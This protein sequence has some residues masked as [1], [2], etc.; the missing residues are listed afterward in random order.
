MY[1]YVYVCMYKFL[2]EAENPLQRK[3]SVLLLFLL[4]NPPLCLLHEESNEKNTLRQHKRSGGAHVSDF[5]EL[6]IHPRYD[7]C[8]IFIY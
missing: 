2:M 7:Y 4:M 1:V 5:H 6:L 3:S 8:R